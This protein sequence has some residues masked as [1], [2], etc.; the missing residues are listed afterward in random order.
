MLEF[1]GCKVI[2]I[3]VPADPQVGN[4]GKSDKYKSADQFLGPGTLFS[5]HEDR[6]Q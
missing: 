5:D 2:R 1:L 3:R 6:V 4:D